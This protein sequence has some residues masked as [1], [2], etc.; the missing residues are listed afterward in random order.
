MNHPSRAKREHELGELE[1][2]V[3]LEGKWGNVVGGIKF[4]MVVEKVGVDAGV[5]GWEVGVDERCMRGGGRTE[6]SMGV[7]RERYGCAGEPGAVAH[8]PLRAAS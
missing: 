4:A 8:D 1:G 5:H 7:S 2:E 6:R 3:G